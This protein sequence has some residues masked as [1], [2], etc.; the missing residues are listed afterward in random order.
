MQATQASSVTHGSFVIERDY[1]V[2][3]ERVFAALSDPAKKRR[4]FSEGRD[5]GVDEFE[6]DFRIGGREQ[7]QFRIQ[8]DNP[9][10]GMVV[11]N[12]TTYQDIVPNRR[13]VY[14][15]TMRMGEHPFSASLAT[16]ELIPAEK[17]THLKF[18]EQ[19][20]FFENADGS[21]MREEG[22]TKLLDSLGTELKSQS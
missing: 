15:Y 11:T 19:S 17:G 1:P 18:T 3:P 4:W 13:I 20:A 7:S 8:A 5:F 2:A 22:W 21:K 6:M 16:F 12:N 14:A 10:K 9:Y